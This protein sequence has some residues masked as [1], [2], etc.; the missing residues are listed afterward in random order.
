MYAVLDGRETKTI[1]A[2]YWKV[3]KESSITHLLLSQCGYMSACGETQTSS[4]SYSKE[5]NSSN[6]LLVDEQHFQAQT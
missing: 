3:M 2:Q 1:S 6:A 5:L 4:L